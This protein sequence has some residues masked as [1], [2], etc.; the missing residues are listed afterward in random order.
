[1]IYDRKEKCVKDPGEY[2]QGLASFMYETVVG[3]ILLRVAVSPWVSKLWGVYQ[4]SR[5]SR[6]SIRPFV[7]KNGV[8]VTEEQLKSFRSFND[9]FTRKKEVV[10][11]Q[12]EPEVLLSP[13]DSKMSYFPI[14]EGLQL[15]IKSS[16]YELEEVLQDPALAQAYRG[17][18]CIIFR[19]A[20][21]DYHRYHFIDD[22]RLLS[23]KKIKGQLH[24]VRSISEKYRVFARNSR[25][26]SVL[27]TDHFGKVVQVEVGAIL[28][29]K[30]QNHNKESFTRLEEK[31]YFEFGGSTILMLLSGDIQFDPDIAENNAEGNEIQVRAGERIGILKK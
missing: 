18:T 12:E 5:L 9:F 13:A 17:G 31:G 3:R 24:T 29:G 23:T 7:E 15:K 11:Q 21:D 30:I 2:R 20:V 6:R 4:S 28:V 19:L 27:D 14:T 1:M 16:T 8:Q 26:V 22:G 10:A 25:Q